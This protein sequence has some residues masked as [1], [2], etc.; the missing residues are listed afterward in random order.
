MLLYIEIIGMRAQSVAQREKGLCGRPLVLLRGRR[1][2]DLSAEAARAGLRVGQELSPPALAQIGAV[3]RQDPGP[4][5]CHDLREELRGRLLPYAQRLMVAAPDAMVLELWDSA[6]A[7]AAIAACR[8]I[9]WRAL[10][11]L[12]RSVRIGQALLRG[13]ET[14]EV[15]GGAICTGER[16]QLPLTALSWLEQP[17]QRRL[18]RLGVERVAQIRAIGRAAL[19][20]QIGRSAQELW[21]F[22]LGQEPVGF[23]PERPEPELQFRREF[24]EGGC[25]GRE[26]LAA[27]LRAGLEA[28]R[29]RIP[30]GRAVTGLEI[31]LSDEA[32]QTVLRQRALLRPT[33]REGRIAVTL[34][35]LAFG[36]PPPNPLRA[37]TLRLLCGQEAGREAQPG[38][39][40]QVPSAPLH[41][42]PRITLPARELRLIHHDPY[43]RSW[44]EDLREGGKSRI[45]G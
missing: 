3:W 26:D 36:E 28:L 30:A 43:R 45:T 39:F 42:S 40:Q 19:W 41:E 11:A 12:G 25:G 27:A 16:G 17:A 4:A 13:G 22:A 34:L 35:A 21:E 2:S 1:I 6:E 15:A 37:V 18:A 24:G 9:G 44:V 10:G 29:G 32:G 20:E 31:L 38:L 8:G 5:A 23:R 14:R 33:R 7:E